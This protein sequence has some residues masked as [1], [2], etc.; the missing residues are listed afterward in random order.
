[1]GRVDEESISL[2]YSEYTFLDM[3]TPAQ[4]Y[5]YSASE[6]ECSKCIFSEFQFID[7]RNPATAALVVNA[8][9]QP[10]PPL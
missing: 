6:T 5:T 4:G 2:G 10:S 9:P 1:M 7:G 3:T 8:L